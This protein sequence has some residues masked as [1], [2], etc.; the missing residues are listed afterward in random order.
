MNPTNNMTI[1]VETPLPVASYPFVAAELMKLE[2]AAEQVGFVSDPDC[3]VQA[4]ADEG[5]VLQMAGGEFCGNAS[6]CAAVYYARKKDMIKGTVVLKVSGAADPVEAAVEQC[7]DGSWRGRVHMPAPISIN[8]ET[9]PDGCVYPVVRFEGIAH[10]IIEDT[11]LKEKAGELAPVWCDHLGAEAIGLMFL[12]EKTGEMTPLVYVPAANT[13]V[14]ESSCAS[15]TTAT[16]AYLAN[17]A[18]RMDAANMQ[19]RS[20]SLRQPGGVLTVEVTGEGAY[21]LSGQVSVQKHA[22]CEIILE[23]YRHFARI[24]TKHL[25]EEESG[26]IFA[27]GSWTIDHH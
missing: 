2:P 18:N 19:S 5:C 9:F 4:G 12:S 26:R 11:G 3:A 16:G 8:D 15:G 20:Y 1:L 24:E 23:K 7:T 10:V 6:M 27:S 13:L 14:W 22:E 17:A 25:S 21:Y